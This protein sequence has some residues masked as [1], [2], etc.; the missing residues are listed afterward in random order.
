MT[1]TA[2]TIHDTRARRDDRHPPAACPHDHLVVL[3]AS[4]RDNNLRQLMLAGL[5]PL[6]GD[7]GVSDPNGT[8]QPTEVFDEAVASRFDIPIRDTDV[9]A[10]VTRPVE[11]IRAR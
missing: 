10:A 4:L 9:V 2:T 3:A 11:A 5:H 8:Y 6:I 1:Q 7:D